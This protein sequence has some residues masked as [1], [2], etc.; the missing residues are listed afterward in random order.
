[1]QFLKN[2]KAIIKWHFNTD[3]P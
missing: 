1:M 3:N 2:K